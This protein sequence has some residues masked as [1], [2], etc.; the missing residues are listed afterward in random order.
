M[1]RKARTDSLNSNKIYH[2]I[3]KGINGQEIFFEDSDRIKFLE[4]MNMTK[5]IYQ[6]DIYAYVLMTNHIHLI[7]YDKENQ[8]SQIMHRVCCIYAMYYNQKYQRKGHLFQNRFKSK[9]VN[10]ENYLL[11]LLRY[12]HKNP[13]KDGI[14]RLDKYRWSSY[15]EYIA[16]EKI[17]STK[18]VLDIFEPNKDIAIRKF[19]EYHKM[20]VEDGEISEYEMRHNLTDEEAIKK[21]KKLLNIENVLIISNLKRELR[22]KY[23]KKIFEIDG[24]TQKQ[25]SRI[26]GI[27]KRTIQRAITGK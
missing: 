1:P 22:D 15:Q 27:G 23:I 10:S 20:N 4:Q 11:N 17:T 13:Q 9:C 2:V 3:L 18:F 8:L 16:V 14:E 6:Y 21:I 24:I 26:L 5:S 25:I 19:I 12:I 7:I